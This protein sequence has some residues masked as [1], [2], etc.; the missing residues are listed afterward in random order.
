MIELDDDAHEEYHRR[1]SQTTVDHGTKVDESTDSRSTHDSGDMAE[2][3][4]LLVSPL[5]VLLGYDVL[6]WGMEHIVLPLYTWLNQ[7]VVGNTVM[8]LLFF[9]FVGIIGALVEG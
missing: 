3:L 5:L 1:R 7:T 4:G 8:A 9:T 2:G 6:M